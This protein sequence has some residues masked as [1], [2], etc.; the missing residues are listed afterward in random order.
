MVLCDLFV[1]LLANAYDVIISH[2]IQNLLLARRTSM[3]AK[4]NDIVYPA[5]ESV[6][7]TNQS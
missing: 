5:Y 1:W 3:S 4:S 7:K 2:V 6:R